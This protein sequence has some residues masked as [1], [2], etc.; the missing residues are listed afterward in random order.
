MKKEVSQLPMSHGPRQTSV[1][2]WIAACFMKTTYYH[3]NVSIALATFVC[4]AAI[5]KAIARKVQEF[6]VALSVGN[7]EQCY[8][9]NTNNLH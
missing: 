7:T 1:G 8:T 9:P 3:F 6:Y 5:R 2:P 4:S